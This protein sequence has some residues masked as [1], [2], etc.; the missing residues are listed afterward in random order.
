[1]TFEEVLQQAAEMLQRLGRVSYRSLKRQFDLDDEN[2]EDLKEGLLYTHSE[3]IKDEGQG[4][5]W[6][7]VSPAL[8]LDVRQEPDSERQESDLERPQGP[9]GQRDSRCFA[10]IG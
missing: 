10:L 6:T 9:R 2:F 7:G 3:R 8:G 1:M 5:A 4:F